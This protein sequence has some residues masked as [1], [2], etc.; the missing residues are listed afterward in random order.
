MNEAQLHPFTET[1]IVR[2]FAERNLSRSEI[3][4]KEKGLLRRTYIVD[5]R[6]IV[7]H[8]REEA[9]DTLDDREIGYVGVDSVPTIR[10]VDEPADS[11]RTEEVSNSRQAHRA[12]KD[13]GI[14][15]IPH[16][17]LG[18]IEGAII[19]GANGLAD[20]REALARKDCTY[21][22]ARAIVDGFLASMLIDD[23]GKLRNVY[24]ALD[25]P[26]VLLAAL[27]GDNEAQKIIDQKTAQLHEKEAERIHTIRQGAA[28]GL[29]AY[30]KKGIEPISAE[31][32]CLVHTTPHVP[33][34]DA[35]GNPI[36]HP[37]GH[38]YDSFPRAT[39]HCTVNSIVGQHAQANDRWGD[40]DTIFVARLN[41]VL[42]A[43]SYHDPNGSIKTLESLSGVDTWF[44]PTPGEAIRFPSI[45]IRTVTEGQ[46]VPIVRSGNNISILKKDDYGQ[47]DL[48]AIAYFLPEYKG[49]GSASLIQLREA[50]VHK[51]MRED[52]SINPGFIDRQSANGQRMLT[53]M[54]EERICAT[55]LSLGL[56]SSLHH[57]T[58]EQVCETVAFESLANALRAQKPYDRIIREYPTNM[59]LNALRFRALAGAFLA[60]DLPEIYWR[61]ITG[62]GRP[63]IDQ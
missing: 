1:S 21:A 53:S 45:V 38:Y 17:P 58:G 47:Q 2:E 16:S 10:C 7:F 48:E 35:N 15:A 42:E 24:S 22:P 52:M 32:I 51:V 30:L 63:R 31:S 43:N 60:L 19:L 6:T 55:A 50:C 20:T 41:D 28:R 44:C 61:K 26:A 39:W 59:P 23:T 37:F 3:I 27:C 46:D 49:A 29:E 9:L 18:I 34:F 33:E 5:G 8:N 14:L 57:E 54:L 36:F 40:T 12:N 56:R 11:L 62:Y 25:G 4:E 13:T